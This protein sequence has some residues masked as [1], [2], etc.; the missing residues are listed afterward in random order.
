MIGPLDVD[1]V[2]PL[3]R[4]TAA[5]ATIA[6]VILT[7]GTPLALYGPT[8]WNLRAEAASYATRMAA[9]VRDV[10]VAQPDLWAYDTPKLAGQLQRIEG[11]EV[12]QVVVIDA[13][14][15]RVDVPR[16]GD[17]GGVELLWWAEAPV[18]RGDVEVATVWVAIDAAPAMARV[19]LA[20]LLS[21]VL[22]AVLSTVLYIVPV[23]AVVRAER[24]IVELLGTVDG[25]RRE[26]AELNAELEA[27]VERRSS[28][29]AETA[30]ALQRSETRLREMA[31]RAVEAAELERQR[32]ARELHDG[33]G[34]TLTA[35]RLALGVLATAR[36]REDEFGARLADAERLVDDS[37]DE[38]RRIAMDLHP[39]A[40]DRLG[41]AAGLEE[42]CS[43]VA[44]RTGLAVGFECS[45]EGAL[46]AAVESTIYRVVQE[47]LTNVARY[48]EATTVSVALEPAGHERLRLRVADDGKGF[49]PAAPRSGLGLKGMGDRAAL[50]GGTLSIESAP[51]RGSTIE[52]TLPRGGGGGDER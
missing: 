52:V 26:L 48:A 41:L 6:A 43:G 11:P 13:E 12:E 44:A 34:Q 24:R 45:L 39:A 22:G 42:L 37:I 50:L 17:R 30:A 31:A 36:G 8:R 27:R 25:A 47:C 10:V 20:L 28:Q 9:M 38:L 35:I 40:L 14:G 7:L 5:A 32:V 19:V 18:V 4:R 16:G 46:P 3:A 23:R 49:D 51:G 15:R 21:F 1:L 29:L 33:A 2:R